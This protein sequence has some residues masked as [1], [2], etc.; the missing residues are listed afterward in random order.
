MPENRTTA[1]CPLPLPG[2]PMRPDQAR[3][4]LDLWGR[5]A[6]VRSHKAWGALREM[7]DSIRQ[8]LQGRVR[9]VSD[10]AMLRTCKAR[11]AA[12]GVLDG[13]VSVLA[14]MAGDAAAVVTAEEVRA[15]QEKAAAERGEASFPPAPVPFY[16]SEQAATQEH[17]TAIALDELVNLPGWRDLSLFLCAAAWVFDQMIVHCTPGEEAFF[18]EARTR[19]VDMLT[20]DVQAAID[21]GVGAA[22]WL[23]VEAERKKE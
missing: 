10:P 21:R 22:A 5:L 14:G 12:A 7:Q 4:M 2:V 8:D 9:G 20:V 19:I 17:E 1:A 3:N 16:G 11:H 6:A 13:L 15:R 23:S 18:Q